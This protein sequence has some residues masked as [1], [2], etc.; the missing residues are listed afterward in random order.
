V[1]IKVQR[2]GNS[3]GVRLSKALLADADIEVGDEVDISVRGREVVIS[4]VR[5]IRGRHDLSELVAR[6]PAPNRDQEVAWGP[7]VGSE[8]W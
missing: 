8:V 6:L 7:A 4:P 5:R 2:W 3:Q 1:I